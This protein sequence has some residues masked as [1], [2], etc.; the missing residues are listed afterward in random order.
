MWTFKNPAYQ[1]PQGA[2]SGNAGRRAAL[3]LALCGPLLAPDAMAFAFGDPDGISGSFDSLLTY[4]AAVRTT[5]IDCRIIGKENG[6]CNIG[7]DNELGKYYSFSRGNGSANADNIYLNTDRGDLNYRKG[8][9]YSNILKGSHELSLDFQEGWTALGRFAWQREFN[10][11]KTAAF[12]LEPEASKEAT[13]RVDLLDLWVAKSFDVMDMPAKIKLGNQ[14]ISWGEEIFVIGGI[15]QVNA[16]N[17]PKFHTPGTQLKEVFVPAPIASL[18][19]GLTEALNFEAYYQFK[20][21]PYIIDPAGT[22]FSP[23]NIVGPG[24]IALQSTINLGDVASNV[25]CPMLPPLIANL[26]CASNPLGTI[27]QPL[28]IKTSIPFAGEFGAPDDNQYGVSLRWRAEPIE[29]EFG[30]YYI[31]YNDKMPSVGYTAKSSPQT[32]TVDN[33]FINYGKDRELFGLS[34]NKMLGPLALAGEVSYRPR[35]TVA[36]DPTVPFGRT[37]TGSFNKFSVFDTGTSTG[38]TEE[39]KFQGDLNIISTFSSSDLLGFIPR[40][41]GATDAFFLGEVAGVYYPDLDLTGKTPYYLPGY[42]LPT[43]QSW[44]YVAEFGLNYPN[45]FDTGVTVTPQI[46]FTHDV[47]GITP[48][49][50]PFFEGRR[51]LTSSLL[52]NFRDR[53]KG[54]LQWVQ[55]W[56]AGGFNTMIDRDYVAGNITRSF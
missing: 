3:A 34:F 47:K 30:I 24:N 38:F 21:N 22:Y 42:A 54:G 23:G 44:G 27:A 29:T 19:I 15:N 31:R 26:L 51:S 4:G 37:L 5:D 18:S 25:S 11:A 39:R 49:A 10:L 6:G 56:G 48:N 20:W 36:I 46:D 12:P 55:Y 45:A 28:S 1:M 2:E 33:Y 53:W 40:W 32:L 9:V 16:I 41:L 7:Y 43:R 14:V 17:L 52:F 50:L 35:D 8:D 13:Q